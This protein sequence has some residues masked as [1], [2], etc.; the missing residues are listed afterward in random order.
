M[1]IPQIQ[2]MEGVDEADGFWNDSIDI[3]RSPS[4]GMPAKRMRMSL[5]EIREDFLQD[6]LFKD[7]ENLLRV[8]R[9]P[10]SLGYDNMN[11]WRT[12][13]SPDGSSQPIQHGKRKMQTGCIPCLCV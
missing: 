2:E 13:F 11:S 6:L 7:D 5:G 1:T 10:E 9:T 8:Q 4:P 3:T 12:L